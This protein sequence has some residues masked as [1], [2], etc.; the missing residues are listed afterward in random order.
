M[1]LSKELAWLRTN[2]IN[3]C[4]IIIPISDLCRLD[5]ESLL[6]PWPSIQVLNT[7]RCSFAKSLSTTADYRSLPPLTFKIYQD[8]ES[9]TKDKRVFIILLHDVPMLLKLEE[10]SRPTDRTLHEIFI[11]YHLNSYKIDCPCIAYMFGGFGC[12]L[13]IQ[14]LPCA[15]TY[16]TGNY[17]LY[18]YIDGAMMAKIVL[19]INKSEAWQL[20]RMVI[21]TIK[22]L[23][24]KIGF[25]HQDLHLGNIVV[26]D[27]GIMYQ[28]PIDGKLYNSRYLPVIIDYARSKIIVDHVVYSPVDSQLGLPSNLYYDL[29]LLLWSWN[30]Y[31]KDIPLMTTG[32]LQATKLNPD[33]IDLTIS[34]L[35]DMYPPLGG[36]N[37][38]LTPDTSPVIYTHSEPCK[39]LL[40]RPNKDIL[41]QEIST[42]GINIDR[43]IE[44]LTTDL[45][46]YYTLLGTLQEPI[47]QGYGI[48][49]MTE[50]ILKYWKDV[51][52]NVHD[53]LKQKIT[54]SKQYLQ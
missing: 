19:Q 17:T 7:V 22:Y 44:D 23:N 33:I 24:T 31:M 48:R 8:V 54:R 16:P 40:N 20:M 41:R 9:I 28:V 5:L 10:I 45:L 13:P 43:K 32:I 21:A 18:E 29:G 37:V 26:R 50:P 51:G 52:S 1:D 53:E 34:T 47:R 36:N 25:V 38:R 27:L 4:P 3:N 42:V 49:S 6:K 11:G 15:V 14:D 39:P 46:T 35:D 2:A 30:S 12:G